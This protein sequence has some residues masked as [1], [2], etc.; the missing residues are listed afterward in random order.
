M[1]DNIT[2]VI[3][4]NAEAKPSRQLRNIIADAFSFVRSAESNQAFSTVTIEDLMADQIKRNGETATSNKTQ[5]DPYSYDPSKP[6]PAGQEPQKP[7]NFTGGT[8]TGRPSKLD[9]ILAIKNNLS[10]AIASIKSMPPED[11]ANT[12]DYLDGLE[13]G[14]P[15]EEDS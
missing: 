6:A 7:A 5:F 3:N 9:F 10:G 8:D 14:P 15:L 1:A 12:K 2:V 11:V 13:S 4:K